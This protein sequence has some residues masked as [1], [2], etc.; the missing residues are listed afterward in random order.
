ML[1]AV[2][3]GFTYFALFTGY[4]DV[5]FEVI[6]NLINLAENL[7]KKFNSEEFMEFAF[8]KS[9]NEV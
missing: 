2:F 8:S 5:I 4:E 7:F 3:I 1:L 6:S 9:V